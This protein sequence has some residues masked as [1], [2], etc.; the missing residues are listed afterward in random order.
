L[1]KFNPN[2][3]NYTYEVG[4]ST[5]FSQETLNSFIDWTVSVSLSMKTIYTYQKGNFV[6]PAKAAHIPTD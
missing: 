4:N 3:N 2:T 6:F 5:L 1:S